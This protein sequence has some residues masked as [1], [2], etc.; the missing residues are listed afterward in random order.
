MRIC[1]HS[2]RR[3]SEVFIKST[4]DSLPPHTKYDHAINLDASFIPQRGKIY[5]LSPHEQKA[6][7]EFLEENLKIGRIN[8]LK[9]LQAALLFFCTK[10]EEVNTLGEDPG[11]RPIQDYQYLNMYTI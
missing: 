3:N 5:P 10:G 7:D 2:Y 4:F 8:P 11:L 9:S 6:L 1:G